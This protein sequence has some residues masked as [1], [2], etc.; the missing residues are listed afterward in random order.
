MAEQNAKQRGKCLLEWMRSRGLDEFGSV[1]LGGTVREVIGVSYPETATKS[2]F[3]SLA[4]TELAAVD[5]VRNILLGEGK[6]LGQQGGDYRIL[7]S[8]ENARQVHLYMSHADKKLKRALKLSRNTPQTD[9]A[10]HDNTA[11]R[12]LMKREAIKSRMAWGD[13]KSA[14]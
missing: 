13:N 8:S 2:Q 5:Y 3:D 1:V 4:L 9:G 10:A 6:Y 7:L 11:A 12:I 14:A